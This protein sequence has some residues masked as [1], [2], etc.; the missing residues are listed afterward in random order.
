MYVNQADRESTHHVRAI[1]NERFD[2]CYI[3]SE[4]CKEHGED[5]IEYKQRCEVS[6]SLIE[7]L[8]IYAYRVVDLSNS[9]DE[10]DQKAKRA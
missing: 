10:S 5:C 7:V 6:L 2:V 9:E 4:G 3:V 1:T 8:F